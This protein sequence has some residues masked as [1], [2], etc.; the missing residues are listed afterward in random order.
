MRVRVVLILGGLALTGGRLAAHDFWLAA[1]PWQPDS[2]GRCGSAR[3]WR[4]PGH[5]DD[6]AECRR[7]E[8][9]LVQQLFG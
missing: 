7:N 6:S 5:R 4:I 2:R 9:T 8:G 1:T 3:P